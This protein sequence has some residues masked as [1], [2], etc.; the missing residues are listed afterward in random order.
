MKNLQTSGL[1]FRDKFGRALKKI[2][3]DKSYNKNHFWSRYSLMSAIGMLL[4][5]AKGTTRSQIL[6]TV[7]S[8]YLENV[9]D[10]GPL[11]FGEIAEP[12]LS[13]S[14][15]TEELSKPFKE[16]NSTL[17]AANRL[18]FQKDFEI[19][20]GFAKETETCYSSEARDVDFGKPEE[21]RKT[22]RKALY[23]NKQLGGRKDTEQNKGNTA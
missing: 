21:A 3:G 13:L 4:L 6:E 20:E 23:N 11:S 5:G 7:F 12:H 2:A 17:S 10:L 18:Y 9:T 22:I 8:G 16:G 19:T 15:L 1:R 14:I